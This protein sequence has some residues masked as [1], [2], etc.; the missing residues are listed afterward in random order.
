MNLLCKWRM[1]LINLWIQV[2]FMP[3][4]HCKTG[5]VS[6]LS[7]EE[8]LLLKDEENP[9][10]FTRTEEDFICFFETMDN[11][12]YDFLYELENKPSKKCEMSVQRTEE[13]AFLH[14]CS[15]PSQDVRL[16]TDTNIEVLER[17]NNTSVFKRTVCVED[18]YLLDP[19]FD[20]SLNPNGNVGQ[21]QVSWQTKYMTYMEPNKQYRIRYSSGSLHNKTE[22]TKKVGHEL[23]LTPGE[24]VEVQVAVKCSHTDTGHWSAWSQPVQAAVPESTDDISL[25]CYTPDLHNVTCHWNGHRY[26][27]E[28]KCKLFYKMDLREWT[29]CL[30]TGNI[31]DMCYFHGGELKKFKVKLSSASALTD[32]IFFSKEFMLKDLIKTSPPGDLRRVLREDKL[33]LEWEAPL[34]SLSAH[35]QYEVGIQIKGGEYWSIIKGPETDTCVQVPAGSQFSVK[36]RAKPTGTIYS[37]NWSDWSDVLTGDTPSD[38]GMLS[39]WGILVSMP[40]IAI[41]LLYIKRSKLKQYFW[42]PVPNLEKVLQGFLTEISRQKWDPPVTAKQT[43]E[44]TSS[45]V[46]E[47]ISEDEVPGLGEPSEESFELLSSDGSFSSGEN[48]DGSPGTEVFPDYVTLNK[49][50]VMLCLEENSYVCELVRE[51]DPKVGDE[52]LQTCNCTCTDGS[53]CI[54]PCSDN[55]F[56]NHCYLLMIEPKDRHNRKI[57][58]RKVPEN[59]YT[60]LPYR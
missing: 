26:R 1:L 30:A 16:F 53:S 57:H 43:L 11:T 13:G 34:P 27:I 8:V 21:L 44:E 17:T 18:H 37:G 28:N 56:T 33:C 2:G 59:L 39:T 23:F 14:I 52:L 24:E 46:V 54:K 5:T 55:D 48:V 45:S 36:I 3:G 6:H 7:K 10:C 58:A 22:E 47:I 20:V 42:P 12:T 50:I 9:K 41:T 4:I 49:E 31:T 38:I 32:R 25:I 35:M 19:P 51:N 60:N 40:M 29:E 15:F